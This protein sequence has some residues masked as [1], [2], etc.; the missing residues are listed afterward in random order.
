LLLV[1]LLL[2]QSQISAL[3]GAF[4]A[5]SARA[6]LLKARAAEGE[7]AQSR[8]CLGGS[9]SSSSANASGGAGADSSHED[10]GTAA[11]SAAAGDGGEVVS[12]EEL[13]SKV[14]QVYQM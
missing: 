10:G 9:S 5:V 13:S 1:L 11:T 2:L 6:A 4:A 3:E 7:V 12:L 8:L 14:A